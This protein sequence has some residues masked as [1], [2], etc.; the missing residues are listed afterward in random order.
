ME[1]KIEKYESPTALIEETRNCE[2]RP[3]L[4]EIDWDNKVITAFTLGE[5]GGTPARV[6]HGLSSDYY[7][8]NNLD[9]TELREW[10]QENIIPLAEKLLPMFSAEWD[11]SNRRGEWTRDENGFSD[12]DP[13]L[14]AI[15]QKCSDDTDVPQLQGDGPGLWDVREWAAPSKKELNAKTTDEQIEIL[16]KEIECAA[17]SENVVLCGPDR[18]GGLWQ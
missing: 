17:I 4:L 13:L 14:Q 18:S 5:N 8:A 9:A 7:L 1:N 15:G 3:I 6:W 2:Q 11:G 12:A 16:A 10:V